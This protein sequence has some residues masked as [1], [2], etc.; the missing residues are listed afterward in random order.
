[1]APRSQMTIAL[2]PERTAARASDSYVPS[3]A[4]IVCTSERWKSYTAR[5]AGET[6]SDVA[7]RGAEGCGEH[8]CKGIRDAGR[9]AKLERK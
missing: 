7:S 2:R 1:M 5:S 6:G 8:K 4:S 9:V 3:I